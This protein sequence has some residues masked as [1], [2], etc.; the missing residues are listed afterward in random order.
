MQDPEGMIPV[1][2][3][4]H[5]GKLRPLPIVPMKIEDQKFSRILTKE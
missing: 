3:D 4:I 5:I 1:Y 2:R